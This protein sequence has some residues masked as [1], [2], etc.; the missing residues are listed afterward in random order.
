MFSDRCMQHN[1]HQHQH[2][3]KSVLIA[4]HCK[5][6]KYDENQNKTKSA[7]NNE[8]SKLCYPLLSGFRTLLLKRFL[9]H[10]V[11]LLLGHKHK[12]KFKF[13]IAFLLTLQYGAAF[14]TNSKLGE[15]DEKRRETN[16][17][18]SSK[19]TISRRSL[20]KGKGNV[21]VS[22]RL[23][24]AEPDFNCPVLASRPYGPIRLAQCRASGNEL[25]SPLRVIC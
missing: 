9:V 18:Q 7:K 15:Q 10:L 1:H 4:V 25:F 5:V 20:K 23:Q 21:T 24:T 17:N 16:P 19:P 12:S 2:S 8:T 11:K 6:I 3:S 14:Q 13:A 22:A